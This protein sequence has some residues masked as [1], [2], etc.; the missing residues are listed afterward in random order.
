MR[1]LPLLFLALLIF[2]APPAAA[3]APDSAALDRMR[4]G[5]PLVPDRVVRW[6]ATEGSWLSVDVSPDGR[7]LVFDMLGDLYTLPIEGGRAVSLTRGM[8]LDAHPRFSPDGTRVV[9]TSDR[10]GGE[11]VWILSLDGRDTVQVTRGKD[12]SYLTPEWT[13]DGDYIVV[14]RAPTRGGSTMVGKLWMYHA[15]GGG[16]TQL[17]REPANARTSS[18]AVSPDGRWIWYEQRVQNWIY[19]TKLSDYQLVV[20]DRETG[21][22][23][24]RT[25]RYG[26]AMRPTLSPDGRWLAYASRQDAETGLVIRDLGTGDERWLAYPV[27]R[28]DQESRASLAAYPGMSFTPDSRSLVATW[29]G[30]LW[31][32]PVEGGAPAEIP[33]EV[34]VEV[35]MA[36]LVDFEFPVSDSATFT[37]RQIENAVPSPDGT[38][39]AFSAL[40]RVYV[41]DL[42]GGTPRRLT[43]A[44]VGEFEPVWSP[45]GQWVAYTTWSD[46]DGGHLWKVRASGGDPVRLSRTPALF[47]QPAWS[48][49]GARV[50]ALRGPARA[51]LE[52]VGPFVP[53]S[54]AD[55]VWLPAGGGEATLVAPADFAN[56]HFTDDPDRI[57]ASAF[58]RGLISMRWDGTDVR[59]HLRVTGAQLPGANGPAQAGWIRMAPRGRKALAQVGYDLYEVD[60]P[61]VGSTPT[62]NVAD[63]GSAAFPVRKLT[64]VGSVYP[65]WGAD[66]QRA[67]WSIGNAFFTYDLARARAF[68][69]SVAAAR[70]AE[71]R[72]TTPA[73]AAAADT[74]VADSAAAAGEGEEEAAKPDRYEPAELRIR[75]QAQRD[76]PRGTVVLRGGRAITMRGDEVV[77]NADVVVRDN[78]IVAVGP[79]GQVQVPADARVVDVSGKTLLPG[80]VDTHAHMWPNWGT[81]REP[82]IYL[83]NLAYGV[84]TTRDPQTATTDV[85]TYADRV[86]AGEILGP[87]VYSTGPGIFFGDQIKSK[88]DA[89]RVLRRY[90][91]YYDTKTLKQ[92]AVGNREQRQYVIQAA[93]E[94]GLMA[95]TEGSLDIAMSL[96]EAF[97]GYSGHEH[98]YPVFP[99]FGDWKRLF[100]ESRIAYTPTLVVAYGAPWAQLHYFATENVH[101][102]PRLRRFTPHEEIDQKA[103]RLGT[104]PHQQSQ[105]WF[106]PLAQGFDKLAKEANDI[107]KA[108]GRVGIGSHGELQGLGYH[109]E[110]WSVASGGMSNHDALRAA[111]IMGA[112]AIGLDR[113]L[114]S[115]EPGKLADILVLDAD[116][117]RD[118]RNSREVRMVM[119][120]GRLYDAHTLD[121]VWPRQRPLGAK[122][123][124]AGD[125]AGGGG[126]R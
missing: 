102:D 126:A 32:V 88:D 93:K 22:R 57:W 95:T 92:Y 16:G 91:D 122:W 54:G 53:E 108:G 59:E 38:K 7:T 101:D 23:S 117:L 43:R 41:M 79:R 100:A 68:E 62:I 74:A 2:P 60:V 66:G 113:D 63:P 21:R 39:L 18:P 112:D 26:S 28:D 109:W 25:F 69:D 37:V 42:P 14:T 82:W 124:Q 90:S 36:P 123:W 97:D 5:L 81:H 34:D 30:K 119:K 96:T 48:P 20:F 27:Q 72:D 33:F 107:L 3:Q 8:A 105:G 83:A 49:D 86:E 55:L 67:H 125:P 6:T 89:L 77:E 29:G 80:Y 75:I 64:E 45:D 47:Q 110:L 94:L 52:S 51:F 70:R 71:A 103:L 114:G 61:L 12:A 40:D 15:E 85:L 11:G 120:N 19:N 115:L 65:A 10:S 106:H 104:Y 121:E 56:P 46:D 24:T 35:A 118:I 116:P 98:S 111:T 17:V 50:V 58:G 84:T 99:M 1:R 73:D 44:D 13:P 31:R 76:V 4:E 78:R 9:F 87:R